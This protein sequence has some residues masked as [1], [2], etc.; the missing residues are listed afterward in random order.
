MSNLIKKYVK[1]AMALNEM[2]RTRKRDR[3]RGGSST[4]RNAQASGAISSQDNSLSANELDTQVNEINE[5]DHVPVIVSI[6]DDKITDFKE[7]LTKF[8][9]DKSFI[10]FSTRDFKQNVIASLEKKFGESYESDRSD[11]LSLFSAYEESQNRTSIDI[12]LNKPIDIVYVMF[13]DIT[14][15][16]AATYGDVDD[17]GN[18]IKRGSHFDEYQKT[19]D[20]DEYHDKKTYLAQKRKLGQQYRFS[21]EQ[22]GSSYTHTSGIV[23]Q[24]LSLTLRPLGLVRVVKDIPNVFNEEYIERSMRTIFNTLN[25]DGFLEEM[26]YTRGRS[27]GEIKSL[28]KALNLD[29]DSVAASSNETLDIAGA[30]NTSRDLE[31]AIKDEGLE[32]LGVVNTAFDLFETFRIDPDEAPWSFKGVFLDNWKA[33]GGNIYEIFDEA[34]NT[35]SSTHMTTTKRGKEKEIT[36][37]ELGELDDTQK[38]IAYVKLKKMFANCYL[39]WLKVQ[40]QRARD[41]INEPKSNPNEKREN[42]QQIL[43]AK[44]IFAGFEGRIGKIETDSS[45]NPTNLTNKEKAYFY[46]TIFN[47]YYHAV[48]VLPYA[49]E[50]PVLISTAFTADR[51]GT[52]ETAAQRRSRTSDARAAAADH[53][54]KIR[55]G[56]QAKLGTMNRKSAWERAAAARLKAQKKAKK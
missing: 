45:G 27:E 25:L 56:S 39:R 9:V 6:L 54:A 28:A 33:A 42:Y 20:Y 41:K 10:C 52:G 21:K 38:E 30:A 29:K 14:G 35:Q 53:N 36:T 55:H 13:T 7:D 12:G 46:G 18:V 32:V 22:Y 48:K 31:N 44:S 37:Y 3:S 49:K 50:V 15:I 11:P 34:F 40:A 17:E 24:Q 19:D 43:T 26:G 5:R 2:R 23:K 51:S 8:P 4:L 1:S 47:N 16:G